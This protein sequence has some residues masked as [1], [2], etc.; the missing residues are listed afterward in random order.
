MRHTPFIWL[1]A[2]RAKK[3]NIGPKGQLLDVAAKAGLPVP[4]GAIL[5]DDL[6]QLLLEAKIILPEN[7]RLITPDPHALH[8]ALYHDIHLPRF[9]KTVAIRSAFTNKDATNKTLSRH[10]ASKLFVDANDPQQLA[11]ALCDVWTSAFQQARHLRHD[12][13]I[14]TMVDTQTTGTAFTEQ[15]FEDDLINLTSKEADKHIVAKD[16]LQLPKIKGWETPTTTSRPFTQRL[17]KLLRGIRRTFGNGDW[18]VEWADDGRICWL[19]QIHPITHP[20]QR[21]EAFTTLRQIIPHQPSPYMTSIIKAAS[22]HAYNYYRQFDHTL[23][24]HRKLVHTF[25]GR[26][27]LNISLLT[28]TMR[29]W[30]LPTHLV[31][32]TNSTTG[33]KPSRLIR[34]TIP[35]L[36]LGWAATTTHRATP[37][38]LNQAQQLAQTATTFHACNNTLR[39]L[40]THFVNLTTTLN[41]LQLL[42]HPANTWLPSP[43]HNRLTHTQEQWQQAMMQSYT[44]IQQTIFKLV[45]KAIAQEQLPH[46]EAFWH[47]T[48]TE[49]EELDNGR[50]FDTTFFEQRYQETETL[51]GYNLPDLIHTAV[52]I[53]KK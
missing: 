33:A 40:F 29:L 2:N 46:R 44:L 27:F 41:I 16:T 8:Q 23:P 3:H 21:N 11:Q 12:T 14:M 52:P 6:Y 10:F 35:L 34:K 38:V 4:S 28:D 20:P 17:Q 50:H 19:I 31:T 15:A 51:K 32:N 26:P 39:D 5:L 45:D 53:V 48:T 22:H 7:G 47:L 18:A 1:G 36:R 49:T 9:D 24:T 13:L 37:T 42:R 43:Y 25:Q 30:G